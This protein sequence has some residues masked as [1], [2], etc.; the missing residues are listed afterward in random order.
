MIPL[1]PIICAAQLDPQV[2]RV[3]LFGSRARGT[4]NAFSDVDI[5]IICTQPA[6][7]NRVTL[8]IAAEKINAPVSFTYIQ[9]NTFQTDD[10]P[11]HVSA[12]IKKEG[13]LLWQR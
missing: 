2:E 11:L 7:V 4:A 6:Q 10:H 13:I 5:A 12:S 8:N 3:Y 9:S 1:D